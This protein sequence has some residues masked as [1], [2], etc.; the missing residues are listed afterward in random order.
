MIG[1]TRGAL[2]RGP[3]PTT[4]TKVVRGVVARELVWL[5]DQGI[6]RL[7]PRGRFQILDEAR[8]EELVELP[9]GDA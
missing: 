9:R 7:L 2:Y 8:L 6:V 1:S 3:Y 4:A 5:R